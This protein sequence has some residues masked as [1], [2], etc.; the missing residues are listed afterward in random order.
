MIACCIEF[1]SEILENMRNGILRKVFENITK[2]KH[3][4]M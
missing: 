2:L 1:I 4:A 3:V